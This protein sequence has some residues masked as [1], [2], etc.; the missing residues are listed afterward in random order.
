MSELPVET[1]RFKES[2]VGGWEIVWGGEKINIET[3]IDVKKRTY[4]ILWWKY[5]IE[6]KYRM[7]SEGK[8]GISKE[9]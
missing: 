3:H 1:G 5:P 8:Q 2:V 4:E 7:L 6:G 9:K